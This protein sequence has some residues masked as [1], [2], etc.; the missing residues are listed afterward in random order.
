MQ[1]VE[2]VVIG[3]G[4]AGLVLKHMLASDRVVLLDPAP[5]SYK[6]GESL[7]PELFRHPEL[8]RLLPIVR[9]LPSYTEKRGTTF[10]GA[11]SV[12]DFPLA[13]REAGVSMHIFRP[14]LERALAETWGVDIVREKVTGLDLGRRIVHTDAQDYEFSGQVIDCSGPAMFVAT[15][16]GEVERLMPVHA[17]W[18]YYDVKL[19]S[20]A[21]YAKHVAERHLEFGRYDP[22]HELV[23]KANDVGDWRPSRTTILTQL[24]DGI[25]SWQIPL[26][27]AKVLSCGVVSRHGPVSEE[28]YRRLVSEH[29]APCFELAPRKVGAEPLDRLHQRNGFARKAKRASTGDFILVSDAFAFS[30][31]VYSVGTGFAVNQAIAIASKL[32]SSAW[33]LRDSEGYNERAESLVSRA[34]SAFDLWYAG[35][36]TTD[37]GAAREVQ[38]GMLHG[39]L[40]REQISQ[41]YGSVLHDADLEQARDPFMMDPELPGVD[42]D[43][44]LDLL[45]DVEGWVPQTWTY[46]VGGLRIDF[47]GSA[48]ETS[49]LVSRAKEG[50]RYYQRMGALGLSYRGDSSQVATLRTLLESV[51]ARMKES[52][53]GW[54]ALLDVATA[55]QSHQPL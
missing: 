18:A 51:A 34:R 22:R 11:D 21:A 27:D 36:V 4:L 37:R 54:V 17:T 38:R 15:T 26:Y 46:S 49:L 1:R 6:I 3:A 52:Q 39:D 20:D 30:D 24:A 16:L 32:N 5:Y 12:V 53:P 43:R 40:F 13:R 8:E 25:W 41:Q 35:K 28:E 29:H 48:G 23:L 14:E 55:A 44:L 7:I 2:H 31:P 42:G 47:K 19:A 50:E 10:V 33:T 9:T 45:G